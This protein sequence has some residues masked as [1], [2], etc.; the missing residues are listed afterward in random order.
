MHRKDEWNQIPQK[1]KEKIL[2]SNG[3]SGLHEPK[4]SEIDLMLKNLSKND[5]KKFENKTGTNPGDIPL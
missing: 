5:N 3:H 4:G 1:E 2:Q